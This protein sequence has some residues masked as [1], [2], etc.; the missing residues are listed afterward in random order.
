MLVVTWNGQA[1]PVA[2]AFRWRL[3]GSAVGVDAAGL[4]ATEKV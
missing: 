4:G 2:R 3:R 1:A